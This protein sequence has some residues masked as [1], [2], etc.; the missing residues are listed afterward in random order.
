V[1]K[2]TVMLSIVRNEIT[3]ASQLP[4][5]PTEI[6]DW[7]FNTLTPIFVIRNP[8]LQIPSLYRGMTEGTQ[9]RPGD[10][11]F[12]IMST[13]KCSR[14]LFENSRANG[15]HPI[16]VDGDDV[17]WRT[18]DVA[19]GVCKILKI[20]PLEL[21]EKWKPMTLQEHTWPALRE[22]TKTIQESTG[23]ERPA[24]RPKDPSLDTEFRK[25]A[26]QWGADIAAQL[27]E[28]VVAEMPHYYYMSQ[29]KV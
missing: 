25:W 29:F 4:V 3:E 11:D 5:N 12:I 2:Q 18:Q 23:I 19:S 9:I 6:S 17:L 28:R 15:R 8:M 21:R 13:L 22:F 27:K 16:T 20:D 26:N 7:L 14:L 1:L 24:A 10:E